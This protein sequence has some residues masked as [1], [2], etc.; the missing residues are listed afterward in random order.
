MLITKK[1]KSN[2][3]LLSAIKEKNKILTPEKPL[4]NP[5]RKNNQN[6]TPKN[7]QSQKTMSNNKVVICIVREELK[8]LA[9]KL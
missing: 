9:Y 8:E 2:D 7:N 6:V 5:K 4:Q 3:E 1:H